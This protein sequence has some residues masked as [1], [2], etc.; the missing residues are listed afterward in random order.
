[1]SDKKT[2]KKIKLDL[3][4]IL[5]D[6]HKNLKGKY[7]NAKNASYIPILKKMDPNIF[8][9]SVFPVKGNKWGLP[10]KVFSVGE[11]TDSENKNIQ[12]TI[13]SVSKVFNLGL[14]IKVRNAKNKKRRT[15]KTG[16]DDISELIGT[17]ESFMGFNDLTLYNI[18]D[19]TQGVPF[20][21][22]PY[23]NAGAIAVV[24]FI[25]PKGNQSTISQL[26][27]NFDNFA[28][29]DYRNQELSLSTFN[30]EMGWIKTNRKLSL[31]LKHLS[32]KFYKEKNINIRKF[33]YFQDNEDTLSI[34]SALANYTSMC[35][36]LVNSKKLVNMSY[37]LAN[38]GV[39]CRG[40][41]V[42][43]CEEN[44]FVLSSMT[45]GGMY[46]ASGAWHQ[47][48]GIPMKSGVGGALIA[49]IPGQMAISIVS[50][51]LDKFGNSEIGTQVILH[52]LDKLKYHTYDYC[53]SKSLAVP[54]LLRNSKKRM[55][56]NKSK[57]ELLSESNIKK[58]EDSIERIK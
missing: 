53:K 8:Q 22:N 14:A 38:G 35:S 21:I 48:V 44:R 13:Q 18:L 47:K 50:P 2:K 7:G 16:V 10:N 34:K 56:K 45:F 52:L 3:Q 24:S 9:I 26:I 1:M 23:I 43:S 15:G 39:N 28:G 12:V 55:T 32:E 11:F 40:K 54:R 57:L 33:K 17:E 42:L 37:T 20:T 31:K 19:G 6:I 51:P 49:I 27:R 29:N 5:N 4:D 25:T 46:N 36:M 41:R 30:N 58:I